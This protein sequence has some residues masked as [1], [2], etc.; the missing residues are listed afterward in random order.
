MAKKIN[1][2]CMAEDIYQ[3]CIRHDAWEDCIIYFNGKAW[4][5]LEKWNGEEG[6]KIGD[7]LYEYE[8]RVCTDYFQYG[9][10]DT[11]S[12]SFEGTLYHILNSYWEWD[13]LT[14][15]YEDFHALFDRYNGYIEFGHAWNFSF[16]EN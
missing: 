10:P 16:V 6:K 15:W 8:N 9:N 12:M 14:D 7:S 11:L 5:T 4:T 2:M 3:W 13:A 1:Y